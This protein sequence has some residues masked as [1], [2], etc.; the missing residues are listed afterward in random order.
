[1]PK[2]SKKITLSRSSKTKISQKS[3]PAKRAAKSKPAAATKIS[4]TP[5]TTATVPI[6]RSGSKQSVVLDMLLTASG[7]SVASI[8]TVTGWQPHSVR[9]F[10]AGVVRKKL[11]LNLTS[12]P[13]EGGRIYRIA[14]KGAAA[15]GAVTFRRAAV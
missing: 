11:K 14:E 9:G 2:A 15:S 10:F 7:A 13:T 1:M 6:A 8:M 4:R 12:V 3:A 5:V